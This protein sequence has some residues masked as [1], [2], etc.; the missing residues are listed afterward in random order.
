MTL[1]LSEVIGSLLSGEQISWTKSGS[2]K[3]GSIHL[4]A[5]GPRRLF[6]YLL[7]SDPAKVADA[8]ESL[9]AGL[10]ESWEA[11][12][13]PAD[14]VSAQTDFTTGSPWRL[15]RLEAS[16]FGGLSSHEGKIFDHLF[17][18][19]NWCLEGQNGSG[20][21]SFASAILWAMTGKRIREQDGLVRDNGFREAVF[22][23][24]GT[25]IGTWPPLAAY[26]ADRSKLFD[27]A[28]VWVRLTFRD[29]TGAEAIAFRK[30]VS[31]PL[32]EPVVEE[33]IDH[34]LMQAPQLIETGLLMPARLATI[35][36]GQQSQPLFVAVRSLTGL[37]QLADIADG[38]ANF[39][40][41]ARRFLK[42]A[43]DSGIEVQ[44]VKFENAAK[45]ATAKAVEGGVT[46]FKIGKLG[47]QGLSA[48]LAGL[49]DQYAKSAAE[50]LGRIKDEISASVDLS[51]TDGRK[52]VAAA[53]NTARSILG[54]G[55]KGI[56]LF[57]AWG[58]LTTA[59]NDVSFN[60]LPTKLAEAKIELSTALKWHARQQEDQKLRLK[61]IGAQFYNEIPHDH[62]DGICPLCE[63][64][65]STNQQKLLA[66]ELRELKVHSADAERKISDVCAT[67]EKRLLG[68]LT[69]D[70][71]KHREALSEMQP[72]DAYR[73]AAIIRFAGE[74]PFVDVLIGI[75]ASATKR[76][77]EQHGALNSFSFAAPPIIPLVSPAD[78]TSL[79]GLFHSLGRL[80]AL[81]GWW[82]GE[83]VA[84]REAWSR[85]C[86]VR[87]EAGYPPESLEG[88]LK[89]LE[90]AN[91]QAKP[92]DELSAELTTASKA[93]VAWQKIQDHQL[94]R[95]NIADALA[96]LKE[97]RALVMSET[98]SS[99]AV[100]SGRIKAILERLY[101]QEKLSY[102]DATLTKKTVE[103]TGSFYEGMHIHAG[104][105]ANTS[106]LRAI[107]WAF[108][109]ALREQT[110]ASLGGNPFPLIVLDDPQATF[111]QRNK[112][113]W[114]A[115]L[116]GLT[117]TTDDTSNSSQLIVTTHERQF[118]QFLVDVE[119]IA[120]QQGIISGLNKVSTVA[121]VVN[122]SSLQRTLQAAKDGNDD[123][124]GYR[125]VS[126]VRVYCEDLLKIML[127]SEDPDVANFTLDKLGKE[128][129]RLIEGSVPPYN[130]NPFR[131]LSKSLTG[132][133]GGNAIKLI[134]DS[135]H[136]KDG[137]IGV[138]QAIEVSKF[139]EKP[140]QAQLSACFATYNAYVAYTGDPRIFPWPENVVSFPPSQSSN[141]KT[142]VLLQT[143]VAAA[144]K[145]DGRA[146]DGQ[147]SIEEWQTV[148]SVRL[149]NHEV[150]Q[151]AAGTL[152]P[153]AGVGDVVIVSNYAQVHEKN[154]VVAAYGQQL[155]A[156]RYNE[157]AVHPD[158]AVLTGHAVD[159]SALAQPVIAPR[160]R[161]TQRKIVGTLFLAN[162]LSVPLKDSDSEV[163]GLTDTT[164]VEA[165]LNGAKLFQVNGRSA[166]PIALDGQF[167]IT[168]ELPF[169]S[170]TLARMEGR[171][172]IAIDDSGARYFKRLRL[173]G[174][175][176]VLESLNPDGTTRS[177]L[178][179]LDSDAGHPKLCGLLEVAGI[180]FELP[181]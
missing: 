152:D 85:L 40:H 2:N 26:P 7:A 104:L 97:L 22:D 60:T 18:G 24:N 33:V 37:D 96:P 93:A 168:H 173:H 45:S 10:V 92:F 124:I 74:A 77:E 147:I 108:I 5:A 136:K 165:V 107:L 155:L 139:W 50:S 72:K 179:S 137:T 114:A 75:A 4:D 98:S 122:G 172:V 53:I 171:L 34:R 120:G 169:D 44:K 66:A 57:S 82:K 106:W 31:S 178:L 177:E 148:Q 133:G 71:A 23:S 112:R 138:A 27:T 3:A 67:I 12:T 180:L 117:P 32:D 149:V 13:D 129:N 48:T 163:V 49:A 84:F 101:Y 17:N 51:T 28:T 143:G 56:D 35:G 8:D 164:I 43:K 86:G 81:V 145:T 61:A 9:F 29:A 63:A 54:Q 156:R 25:N 30:V 36:F 174:K 88:L 90:D 103:V 52:T 162:R 126:D 69:P 95:E 118:F 21:T 73:D 123:A 154:L 130:R 46:N 78:V 142:A 70:L 115:E 167:L 102:Q 64:G 151:V 135:H 176:V 68:L 175:I 150:Y 121:T 153:V 62:A 55:G 132:G 39:G 170:Q 6:K 58:A 14:D 100:L 116:V 125:Y 89:G 1:L 105:V 47:D 127:R 166:E 119:K 19:E 146:G 160:E 131:E 158:I 113:R 11:E 59:A 99:I 161:V 134:N 15:Y 80:H 83:R 38:A 42:F 16:S 141:I 79:E 181:G 20:K 128:L 110:V 41:A 76:I 109:L 65:L 140:L 94:V 144:A 111:D 157:S 87:D 159:P 91:N